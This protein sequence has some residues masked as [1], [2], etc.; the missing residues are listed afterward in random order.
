MQETTGETTGDERRGR[1]KGRD[2]EQ[3]WLPRCA[4]RGTLAAVRAARNMG[5]D[6]V[7]NSGTKLGYI[8]T[9]RALIGM[10]SFW[11]VAEGDC[12]LSPPLDRRAAEMHIR[13]IVSPLRLLQLWRARQD[14][15]SARRDALSV[16]LGSQEGVPPLLRPLPP[17]GQEVPAGTVLLF[18]PAHGVLRCASPWVERGWRWGLVST[19]PFG[20]ASTGLVCP[21]SMRHP[22]A[23]SASRHLA[24]CWPNLHIPSLS[25]S[26]FCLR[27]AAACRAMMDHWG[28]WGG[29]GSPA[30]PPPCVAASAPDPQTPGSWKRA[31]AAVG[32]GAG[33]RPLGCVSSRPGAVCGRSI[34]GQPPRDAAGR[35]VRRGGPLRGARHVSDHDQKTRTPG[36]AD[37]GQPPATSPGGGRKRAGRWSEDY[38]WRETGG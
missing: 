14:E 34:R 9:T 30:A 17:G 37:G 3:A 5:A 25:G 8:R 28:L 23:I 12:V 22:S 7:L 15:S 27:R 31:A 19:T 10:T 2:V 32:A 36:T 6:S 38:P 16:G 20:P 33:R 24:L 1:S 35:E 4:G 21:D 26:F 18:E 29:V 11:A 13:S